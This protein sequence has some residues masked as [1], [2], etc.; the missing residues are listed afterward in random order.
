MLILQSLQIIIQMNRTYDPINQRFIF[1]QKTDLTSEDGLNATAPLR[2]VSYAGQLTRKR[3]Q[4]VKTLRGLNFDLEKQYRRVNESKLE[5]NKGQE[6]IKKQIYDRPY[7]QEVERTP[8]PIITM[9]PSPVQLGYRNKNEF[10]IGPG[11]DV[12][13]H[14]LNIG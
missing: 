1:Q 9:M 4:L 8:C 14:E 11:V 13:N 6:N 3:A 12:E 2:K 5:Q 7:H 10:T